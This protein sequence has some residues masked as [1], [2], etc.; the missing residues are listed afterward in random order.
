MA[1]ADITLSLARLKDAET[2]AVMS[3]DLIEAGLGWEYRPQ[4]IA[5]FIVDRNA[6]TLIAH[7]GS[8]CAGFAVMTFGDERAHLVLLAVHPRYRRRGV[9]SRMLAWLLDSARTAG[10][11]SVH[12]ELLD[13][14][15]AAR[16]F[17][18]A[19]GFTETMRLP[20]YYRGRKAAMRMILVLRV[21]GRAVPAWVPPPR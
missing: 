1:T 21:P 20:R 15:A 14:N 18:R 11:S 17:Y 6:V 2:I 19:L 13:D 16:G 8:R 7:D 4:R 3:R 12:L 9:G 10:L 5:E